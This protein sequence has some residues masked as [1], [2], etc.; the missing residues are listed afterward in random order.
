MRLKREFELTVN[1]VETWTVIVEHETSGEYIAYSRST[2]VIGEGK[3]QD[4]ALEDF[5][6]KAF[7]APQIE[8][9]RLRDEKVDAF[10]RF[11]A[12][13]RLRPNYIKRAG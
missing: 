4:D 13:L 1:A 2:D 3:T 7:V 5:Q 11:M 10:S 12:K 9:K 6:H 8:S